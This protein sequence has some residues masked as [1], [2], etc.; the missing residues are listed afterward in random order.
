M[1]MTAARKH[2]GAAGSE[3]NAYSVAHVNSTLVETFKGTASTG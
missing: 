1:L 3:R 2:D